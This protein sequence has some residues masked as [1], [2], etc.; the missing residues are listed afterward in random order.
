MVA[1]PRD[2]HAGNLASLEDSHALWDFHRVSIDEHLDRFVRVSEFDSS[3]GDW[4]LWWRR[5]IRGGVRLGLSR[6][7]LRG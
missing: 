6:G 5:G 2:I 1:K 7:G 3:T 4:G